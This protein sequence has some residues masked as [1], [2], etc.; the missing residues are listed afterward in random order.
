MIT[1]Y[2]VFHWSWVTSVTFGISH[3]N[4]LI[5]SKQKSVLQKCWMSELFILVIYIPYCTHD[6][7]FFQSMTFFYNCIKIHFF[8][9]MGG[10]KNKW[11]SVG[12][13]LLNKREIIF[14]GVSISRLNIKKL[15]FWHFREFQMTLCQL[16]KLEIYKLITT[17][18]T[19]DRNSCIP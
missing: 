16:K 2:R 3:Y 13:R 7:H 15:E 4:E 14:L 17:I 18:I 5:F 11:C 8:T 9:R 1:N 19:M 12:N 6:F 10:G